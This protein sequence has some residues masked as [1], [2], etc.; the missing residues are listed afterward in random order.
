MTKYVCGYWPQHENLN[1]VK[2][3]MEIK[4]TVNDMNCK[5]L[6]QEKEISCKIHTDVQIPKEGAPVK[7][8]E[9][10]LAA[11]SSDSAEFSFDSV[12]ID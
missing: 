9:V 10:S 3:C 6:I 8:R 4:M 11:I 1:L 2:D 7:V 12:F 5:A